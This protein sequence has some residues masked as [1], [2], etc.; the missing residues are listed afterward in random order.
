MKGNQ[1]MKKIMFSFNKDTDEMKG[2]VELLV[3]RI[4]KNFE[5]IVDV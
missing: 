4:N 2:D 1:I 3:A 5:I